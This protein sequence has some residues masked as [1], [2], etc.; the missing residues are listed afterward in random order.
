MKKG[1]TLVELLVVVLIIG[2]LSSIALPLYTNAVERSR[3]AEGRIGFRALCDAV[4]RY[5]LL[6]GNYYTMMFGDLDVSVDRVPEDI[7]FDH[8]EQAHELSP[9]LFFYNA[10]WIIGDETRATVWMIR[11]RPE[12]NGMYYLRRD[13]VNNTY[14]TTCEDFGKNLCSKFGLNSAVVNKN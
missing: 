3:A 9:R 12:S 13:Y 7:W 5:Y 11:N 4:E 1:F 2:V 6:N 14:T 8:N 10:S